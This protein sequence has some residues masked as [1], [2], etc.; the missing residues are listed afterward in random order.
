MKHTLL[1]VL[2]MFGM[3]MPTFGVA[4]EAGISAVIRDQFADFAQA[5]VEGAFAH[6]SPGLRLRFGTAQRFGEMVQRG[7]PMV[8]SAKDVAFGPLREIAGNL[9]QRVELRDA[10]GQIHYLDYKMIETAEGWKIDAVQLLEAPP[11]S[12]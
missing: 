3:A 12:V 2:L 6:A 10:A 5:D 11:P 9:W 8:W 4:Q 1:T 7:Y